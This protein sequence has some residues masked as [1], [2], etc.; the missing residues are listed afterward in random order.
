MPLSCEE[1]EATTDVDA[2]QPGWRAYILPADDA[3]DDGRR[4]VLY[5]PTCAVLEFGPTRFAN[6]S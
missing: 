6:P 4:V 3:L 5:C 2:R 1:C